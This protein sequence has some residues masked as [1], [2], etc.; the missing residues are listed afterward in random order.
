M[1]ISL[2]WGTGIALVYTAFAVATVGFVTFAMSRAVDL[3][4][5]DYYEQSLRQDDRIAALRR[6]ADLGPALSLTST[7]DTAMLS[8][9]TEQAGHAKGTVSLYRPANAA[10]D[11][12]EPLRLDASGRHTVTLSGLASGRWVLQAQWSAG[13]RDYYFEWPV[14]VP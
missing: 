9:P 2:N 8:M 4:S 3:V 5:A 10:A 14:V 13:G 1:R 12:Q 6:A 7:A 11:R